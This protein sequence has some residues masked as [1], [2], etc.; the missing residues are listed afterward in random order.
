[1]PKKQSKG[2]VVV[3]SRNVN[4][5]KYA[6]NLISG[7]RDFYEDANITLVTEPRFLDDN[8]EA[9]NVIHCDN[10]Y[11]AK[12]W[13]MAQSPY[14]ITMYVDA[15]MDCEHEDICKVWDEMKDYDMVFHQ[16]TK[17]REKFYAIRYFDYEGKQEQFTLCG[18]FVYIVVRILWLWNLWMTGMTS[19]SDNIKIIGD[20]R[21]L[22]KDSGMMI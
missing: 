17:E 9:D 7:I 22:I 18:V 11:R 1:M 19:L 21:D 6:C 16:L 5:Y 15:D 13:G 14:D 2:F 3:A 8:H 12:L 4:F 10:N 20:Q